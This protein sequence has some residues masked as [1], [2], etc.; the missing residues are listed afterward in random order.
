[1]DFKKAYDRIDRETL[2]YTMRA[3]NYGENLIE[4]VK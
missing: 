2:E 3:M 1:M 4:M